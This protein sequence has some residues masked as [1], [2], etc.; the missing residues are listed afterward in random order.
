MYAKK[1]KDNIIV[2]VTTCDDCGDNVGGFYCEV[3]TDKALQ[4][5]IDNFTINKE[6]LSDSTVEQCIENYI[7]EAYYNQRIE[8][9]KNDFMLAAKA[10]C[11]GLDNDVN[12]VAER[13]TAWASFHRLTAD[14]VEDLC[15]IDSTWMFNQIY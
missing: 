11:D 7:S 14:E 9:T 2:Y 3:Y 15:W 1:S 8:K 5:E 13:L 4:N 6:W 12:D 10:L